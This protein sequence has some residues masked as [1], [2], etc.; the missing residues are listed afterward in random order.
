MS[1]QKGELKRADFSFLS[2]NAL[3]EYN[4]MIVLSDSL[5]N[6]IPKKLPLFKKCQRRESYLNL[7]GCGTAL[8]RK[9]TAQRINFIPF[10]SQPLTETLQSSFASPQDYVDASGAMHRDWTAILGTVCSVIA[11][12][13][14]HRDTTAC[15]L[16]V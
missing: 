3:F 16:S 4:T 11:F 10:S 5:G 1:D 7:F 9:T 6:A 8:V 14:T 13:V 15:C 2:N 12:K